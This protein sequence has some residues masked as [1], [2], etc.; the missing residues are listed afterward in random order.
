MLKYGTKVRIIGG[1]HAGREGILEDC[2]DGDGSYMV[3]ISD[4][5]YQT[6]RCSLNAFEV[7]REL[8]EEELTKQRDKL[9]EQLKR[10]AYRK[11]TQ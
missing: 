1:F 2:D 10:L 6:M 4:G 3:R 7:V 8:T 5:S 9:E 11:P